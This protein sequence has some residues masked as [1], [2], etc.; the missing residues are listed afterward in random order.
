[1][2]R[3]IPYAAL[4][5]IAYACKTE[6]VETS[7]VISDLRFSKMQIS[8]DATST[9]VVSAVVN[10]DSDVGLRTVVF[11][12]SAGAFVDG[13]NGRVTKKAEFKGGE[14]VAEVTLKAPSKPGAITVKAEMDVPDFRKDYIVSKILNAVESVPAKLRLSANSFS[15]RANYS[16][17][18]LLTARVLNADDANASSGR[19]IRFIDRYSN[20]APVGGRYRDV[21]LVTDATSTAKAL[22]SPGAVAPGTRVYIKAFIDEP[23]YRHIADSIEVF[24]TPPQ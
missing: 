9:V 1:M 11:E 2:I 19:T 22:Y 8:A 21:M 20:N 13:Q 10:E 23:Q 17:E 3:K 14:L 18:V 7:D 5:F 16:S 12:T 4:L 6:H 24:V 15:V